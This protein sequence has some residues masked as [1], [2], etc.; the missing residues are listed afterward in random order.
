VKLFSPDWLSARERY[1]AASR[2][3]T[4]LEAVVAALAGLGSVRIVDLGCGIGSTMRAVAPRID[5]SQH[6]EL[7]DNDLGLLARADRTGLPGITSVRKR[8]LDLVQDLETALDG[9][10]DLVTASALLDLVSAEWLDR[11]AVESAARRLPVYAALIHNGEITLEPADV[12]DAGVIAAVRAHLRR[13]KGFGPALG[14]AAADAATRRFERLGYAVTR[15]PSDWSLQPA[16][17][18]L[19]IAVLGAWAGAAWDERAM[20]LADVLGWLTQ[21]RDLVAAGRST[22]R[23]GH[24]D[25][26]A[27]PRP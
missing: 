6:W 22:M 14:A 16:D 9:P 17:R 12:G 5:A 27:Q 13:D 18:E 15:G 8:P 21:R 24:D 19:Q 3:T 23:L 7:V 1:D 25:L 2:N 4:V 11:F 20:P 26:F 10:L